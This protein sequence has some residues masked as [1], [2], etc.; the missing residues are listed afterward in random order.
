MYLRCRT[1]RK[2]SVVA[3]SFL[4]S[5]VLAADRLP[6]RSG[7]ETGDFR[8]W[9][10]GLEASMQVD[11]ADATE[12]RYSTRAQMTRGV[13]AD[14]YKEYLFGDHVRIGGREAVSVDRGIWLTLDSKFESGFSFGTVTN[15]HKI[16]LLNLEDENSRRRYQIIINVWTGNRQYYIEHLK[17]NADRSFNRAMPGGSQNVGTPVEARIGQ[18]DRLK[19]FVRPNTR[20]L[21]DGVVRF[22]VNGVLKAEYTNIALR[23]DTSYMPNKLLMVN[24]VTDTTTSG[25]QRWDNFYL[26]EFDPD[27]LGVRP[28][29]PTLDQV[30]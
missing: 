6:F 4:S 11:A 16:A 17:W 22:W 23:E 7:F 13:V 8:D 24:Y 2:V 28:N 25:V 1:L 19:L 12:G 3:L 20:G 18:W 30:L 21:A 9:N 5:T 10:G 29:P 14:N 27:A 15:L 26:G